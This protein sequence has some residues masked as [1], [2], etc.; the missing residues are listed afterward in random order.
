MKLAQALILRADTQKRLE[1]L[2]GRLLDNAKMQENER[3]SEDPKLLLKELDRL[4]DELFRLI[5]AI[6][7]TNSSAK[8]EGTSLT[9]MIAKKDTLSQKVSVLREFAKSAS[10]KVDLY[11]NS[12]IKIL[13]SVDVATLQKQIDELSKEIRE[14]DMKLQ[15]ANWQVDLVE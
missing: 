5:L 3:P 14:L 6:N 2:K 15:E 1:Q 11:S 10:Q 9:E 13:S 4:S 8:F 12:E 7:L